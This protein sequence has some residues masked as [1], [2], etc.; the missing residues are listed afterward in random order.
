MISDPEQPHVALGTAATLEGI[1]DALAARSKPD[2]EVYVSQ[3]G[4]TRALD[5]AE[6]IELDERVGAA[7]LS[8]GEGERSRS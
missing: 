6:Q 4:H 2:L 7:R 3:D 5:A 8:S 1:A